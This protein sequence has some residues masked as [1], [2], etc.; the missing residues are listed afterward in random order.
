MSEPTDAT[1]Y[2]ATSGVATI[3]LNRP[4]RKN[5]LGEEL[6]TSL[7]DNL[8]R[9]MADDDVR[10][11]TLTN[12]GNTF[13]AGADLKASTPGV[14]NEEPCRTFTE[15]F[16]IILA[17]PKYG[18]VKVNRILNQCRISPSKTIGVREIA[19][20]HL[21]TRARASSGPVSVISRPNSSPPSRPTRS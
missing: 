6:V 17:V 10:V 1:L 4:E 13:C 11:V 14:A 19:R 8:D 12:V 7:A 2:D 16:D 5:S 21:S 20:R 3:T 9:A 15:V 18:R